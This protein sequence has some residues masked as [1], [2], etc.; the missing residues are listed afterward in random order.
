MFITNAADLACRPGRRATC[1]ALASLLAIL[2]TV[3]GPGAEAERHGVA[4]RCQGADCAAPHARGVTVFRGLVLDY[5]VI[6]GM[7]VHGGDMVLGTAEEAAA[8]S[9]SRQ[10]AERERSGGPARRDLAGH[11][12]ASRL[13]PG[14]RVPY[15]IDDAFEGEQ[16][17]AVHAAIE[18]WNS[19]T[20]ISL[21]PRTGE[22]SYVRFE[23][24][25][26]GSCRAWV[27]YFPDRPTTVSLPPGCG[28]WQVIHE[29]GHAVGL[30]HEHQRPDRDR[31][32]A[33]P[34]GA[35]WRNNENITP[36]FFLIP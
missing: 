36:W 19:K 33:L 26:S 10:P 22:G 25:S 29:I 5:E 27:G 16:R 2:G 12:S 1:L 11:S 30:L 35:A 14:G 6:D 32:L 7:A 9:P 8:A 4:D 28:T 20:V 31:F 18:E 3:P 24:A 17:E 15:E 23:P 13:W 34:I 21:F